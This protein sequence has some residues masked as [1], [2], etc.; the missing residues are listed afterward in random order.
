MSRPIDWT[1]A[2]EGA[3]HYDGLHS[4]W[5]RLT[6]SGL[7]YSDR[8]YEKHGWNPS[9]RPVSS[10]T[11]LIKRPVEAKGLEPARSQRYLPEKT[12]RSRNRT[13]PTRLKTCSPRTGSV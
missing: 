9:A 4:R 3:T 2:P 11:E 5:Y 12:C 1:N 6:A 8:G 10:L 13:G 7:D